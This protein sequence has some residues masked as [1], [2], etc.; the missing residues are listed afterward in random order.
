MNFFRIHG[1]LAEHLGSLG[2]IIVS[3]FIFQCYKF[4]Q[5]INTLRKRICKIESKFDLLDER[6][7]NM[8][9]DISD[10]KSSIAKT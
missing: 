1:F 10:I 8:K 4:Y 7:R 9:E 6:D 2:S 5:Y 3:M